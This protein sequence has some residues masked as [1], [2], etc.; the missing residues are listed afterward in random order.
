MTRGLDADFARIAGWGD[1]VSGVVALFA[2]AFVGRPLERQVVRTWNVIGLVD[3]VLV[4]LTAQ[5]IL[6][7]SDHPETMALFTQFPFPLI[8]LFVVPLVIATHLL[9]FRRTSRSFTPH[10]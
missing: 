6:L 4:V 3:I 8:P 9:V 10:A 5:R 7:F 1:I 2:A